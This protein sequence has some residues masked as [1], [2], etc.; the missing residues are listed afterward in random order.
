MRYLVTG[1]AGFIG[2]NTVDELV[3][4]GHNVVVLDDLSSGKAENLAGARGKIELL[5][6]SIADL[7]RLHEACRGVDYVLHMAARTSVPR[8]VKE[9]LETNRIN[10]DGTLNVLVAARDA[11]VKRV[12]FAGSSA[13][14]GETPTLPKREDMPPAPISPYGVS[15]LTGEIYGQVFQRV[16]GLEFVSLR[17]FNV[18]GPR[19][20]PG[21]PY[22]G[23]LSLFNAAVLDGTQPTIYGDG[24]QSRDFTYVGNVVEANLLACEAK[25]A[26]GRAFNIGT[27]NRYTLNQTLA[28]MEKIAGRPAKAKYTPPREGDIRDSQADISRARDVLGYNPRFGFE[29]GLK[30]TWEWFCTAQNTPSCP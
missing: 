3:R 25:R 16:Y 5:Q 13:V 30:R 8:S 26:A 29:E 27:G 19:Q 10:V 18:F 4:R 1:G 17:Y 23:V 6:H 20:D 9:P 14:Y 28:M 2:S 24:E 11:K 21:S 15:K 7:D 22:S 12:V